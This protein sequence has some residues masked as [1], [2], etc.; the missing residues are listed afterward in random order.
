MPITLNTRDAGFETAFAALLDSKRESA[1]DVDATV[2]AIIEEVS[3]RGDAAL[4]EYTNRFDRIELT[5]AGLRLTPSEIAAGADAAPAETVDALRLAA[6]RIESFHRRQL[7]APIDYVDTA[8]VRLGLRWRPVAAAGLYVP[9]GTASYPSSVLMNAIPAKV[10]GVERLVMT[11][12]APDGVLNPLVLAAARLVGI[13]EIYRVGGAQ[14]VAALAYGTATIKPVDKIVG[15]GNAY[16]AAAKRRVFGKVGIDMI[17]G[18]S[19]ILVIADGSAKP[20]WV[21]MDVFSQAE[22]GEVAQAVL[23]TADAAFLEAVAQSMCRG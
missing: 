12:P 23:V 8:G 21:A 15:P 10:A 5:A 3:S 19:E 14:A 2:A 11:V 18:P 7:P 16:V 13:D 22:H 20:D 4:I 9:G 6:E 17:A 1:A